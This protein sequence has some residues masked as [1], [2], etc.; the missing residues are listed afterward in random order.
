MIFQGE[1]INIAVRAFTIGYDFYAPQR[2][3][4]FHHYAVRASKD[5][6]RKVPSFWENYKIAEYWKASPKT[7]R[8]LMGVVHMLPDVPSEIW[9][10]TEEDIYGIGGVRTPEKFY[11]TFGIDVKAKKVEKD[12]CS[13][14]DI[15]GRMHKMFTRYLRSD[16]M[17]IDYGR[18]TYRHKSRC[19]GTYFPFVCGILSSFM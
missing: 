2:S 4:C 15:S 19:V 3:V 16:G 18:I 10:H 12:L 14:V 1:E 17:G 11:Q 8:R 13:F 9:D 6:R 7:M 5:K